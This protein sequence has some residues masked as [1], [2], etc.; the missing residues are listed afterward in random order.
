M[1]H[2]FFDKSKRGNKY[3]LRARSGPSPGHSFD[4]GVSSLTG[5]G[6]S[7]PTGIMELVKEG[8]VATH[9]T[10]MFVYAR[11]VLIIS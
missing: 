4:S 10:Y 1:V 5:V 7:S 11:Y 2:R 6:V 3:A 8:K 9:C